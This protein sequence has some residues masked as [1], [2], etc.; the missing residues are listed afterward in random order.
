MCQA[1][2]LAKEAVAIF[3]PTAAKQ[4]VPP[5]IEDL[6]GVR[7]VQNDGLSQHICKKC[8]RRL[9]SL[10]RATEDLQ[11]FRSIAS[12]SYKILVALKL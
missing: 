10:E 8:K 1:A 11:E 9:E 5:R 6:L 3:G 4:C 12:N 2:V 7:V